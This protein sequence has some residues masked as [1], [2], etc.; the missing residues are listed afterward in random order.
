MNNYSSLFTEVIFIL[1]IKF[2]ETID[3]NNFK[4]L[5]LANKELFLLSKYY[6]GF[7]TYIKYNYKLSYQHINNILLQHK[8]HIKI[9]EYDG[10][11][12][13][14]NLDFFSWFP[15]FPKILILNNPININYYKPILEIEYLILI[16]TFNQINININY[17]NLPNLKF[18]GSFNVDIINKPNKIL[19]M[20]FLNL[21]D[22][23]HFT[24]SFIIDS[25]FE[26][27]IKVI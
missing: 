19:Q 24:N 21:N 9:V 18:I 1:Y 17:D 15:V 14:T 3:Q 5:I 26:S 13:N 20:N 10:Y 27:I 25:M 2:I 8:P 7:C 6:N 11:G 16:N 23:S 22:I 12:N 4:N